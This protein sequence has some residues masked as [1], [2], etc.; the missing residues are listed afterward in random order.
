MKR[1]MCGRVILGTLLVCATACE[2]VTTPTETEMPASAKVMLVVVA[3]YASPQL[4]V[5]SNGQTAGQISA[6]FTGVN[7]CGTLL[8]APPAQVVS[9]SGFVGQTYTIEAKYPSGNGWIWRNVSVTE[10]MWREAN[11]YVFQVP[12][13]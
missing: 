1:R 10:Q 8:S 5:L 7:N 2:P 3:G 4:T 6:Q 11:C 13:P 12:A 9:I